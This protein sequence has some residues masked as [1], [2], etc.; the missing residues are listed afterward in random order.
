MGHRSIGQER[1]GFA[2]RAGPSS[3]L[4][5]AA[6]GR[7][8]WD[9]LRRLL[10]ASHGAAVHWRSHELGLDCHLDHIRPRREIVPWRTPDRK[11]LGPGPLPV[12]GGNCL[13]LRSR[14]GKSAA[15]AR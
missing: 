14:G 13:D 10:L 12:G 15:M 5:S 3:S 9:L 1:F 2:G 6:A 7:S 8:P 11:R 4:D